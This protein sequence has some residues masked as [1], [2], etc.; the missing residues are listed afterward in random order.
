MQIS[1]LIEQFLIYRET[2]KNSSPRTI[3]NY[4]HRLGRFSQFVG[5]L[6]I[7]NLKLIHITNF[8]VKLS[9]QKLNIKTINY[10]IIALRAF[11]KFC[12]RNDIQT[13]ALEKIELAKIPDRVFHFLTEE[14][15]LKLMS[16][17]TDFKQDPIK[18]ARDHAILWILYGSGLRVTE[19]CEL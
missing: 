14:S 8:R 6:T 3:T 18:A 7:D 10:H 11:L 9:Q 17:P 12:H 15:V 4:R 5:D 2:V 16:T 1:Q 19:L 13:I